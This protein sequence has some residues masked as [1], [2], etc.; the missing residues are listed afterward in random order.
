MK[1]KSHLIEIIIP[2][3]GYLCIYSYIDYN[4][5]EFSNNGLL[6]YVKELSEKYKIDY[7]YVLSVMHQESKFETT[8]KSET[9][10]K[11][12]WQLTKIAIVEINRCYKK[13]HTVAEVK[14]DERLNIEYS[15]MYLALMF[16]RHW[17]IK[18]WIMYYNWD[19]KHMRKYVKIVMKNYHKIY[20]KHK[21]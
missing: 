9:W 19:T 4:F 21:W 12:F 7:R 6:D 20:K 8:A 10:A 2:H 17:S 14:W 5:K 3:I 13:T 16:K 11:G 1:K 18:K 15:I